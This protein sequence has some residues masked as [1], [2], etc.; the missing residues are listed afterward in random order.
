M[1][2]NV[3]NEWRNFG[4]EPFARSIFGAIIDDDPDRALPLPLHRFD[5]LSDG[6]IFIIARD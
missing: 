4:F 5:N 1:I 3:V 6:I 2:Q